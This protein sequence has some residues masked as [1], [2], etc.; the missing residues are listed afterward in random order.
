ATDIERVEFVGPKVGEE[1]RRNGIYA[2]VVSWIAILI[3]VGF[4]FSPLYAP[5][6]VIALIHDV[7]ITTG[8]WGLLGFEFDLQVLAALLTIIGYS[9]NDTIIIYDRIRENLAIRTRSE[10]EE[11]INRSINQTLSRAILTHGTVFL[12]VVA[13][14]LLGGPV[15]RPFSLAMTFGVVV[16]A[17]S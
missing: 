8:L 6:A 5:G 3:Y 11:V 1:L 12:A 17:Y 2:I 16:G 14:D 4:R 13:L 9:M 7:W 10:L 15:I